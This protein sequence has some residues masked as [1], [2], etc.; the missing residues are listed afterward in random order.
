MQS[1]ATYNDKS[2]IREK[3]AYC[4]CYIEKKRNLNKACDFKI[5]KK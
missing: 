2:V 4:P 1:A 5:A 3:N